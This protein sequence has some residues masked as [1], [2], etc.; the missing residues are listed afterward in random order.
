MQPSRPHTYSYA[1]SKDFHTTF[2]RLLCESLRGAGDRDL[3]VDGSWRL[4]RTEI[5]VAAARIQESLRQRDVRPG[6]VVVAQLPNWWETLAVTVAVWGMGAV[7]NLVTPIYRRREMTEIMRVLSPRLAI[8]PQA[9]RGH[10]HYEVIASI[11]DDEGIDCDVTTLRSEEGSDHSLVASWTGPEQDLEVVDAVDDIALVMFTSGTTGRPKGVLHSQRTLLY[12][13]SSIGERFVSAGDSVFMP[14]PLGHI[15]GLLFGVLLPVLTDGEVVLMDRWDASQAVNLI[16]QNQCTFSVGATPFLSGLV[17]EYASVNRASSLRWFVCGGADI[18]RPLVS[19]A[20]SVMGTS[21]ARAYGLTE[22]PTLCCGSPDDPPDKLQ[23]TEGR[24]V[25]EAAARLGP[26]V[27]NAHELEIHGPELF[28]GYL[29]PADNAAAF[30]PDGWFRT[31]DLATIDDDYVTI[32]GR[33]KDM[34]VRG[35]ENIGA[36]EIEDLACELDWIS[37]AAV[38]GV[39]DDQLGERACIFVCTDDQAPTLEAVTA[40]LDQCGLARQKWPEYLIVVDS[41]PR[42]ASGKVQKFMLRQQAQ[43]LL[44]GSSRR[45]G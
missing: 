38:V 18:P 4:T 32:V 21:V 27:G 28:L 20:Q 10:D 37:E 1:A 11:V 9:Y 19:R 33:S 43:E 12:E 13:A 26:A 36:K 25:G 8:A 22:M 39:P 31:G 34:I 29:D 35:G 30:T 16:E 44:A 7:L 45:Q 15:T 6:D 23:T 24:V 14:S 3:V 17:D 2:P 5:T 42:T 41:L 40:H